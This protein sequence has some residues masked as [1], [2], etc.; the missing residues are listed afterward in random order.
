MAEAC[1]PVADGLVPGRC[2]GRLRVRAGRV[3]RGR[4]IRR[5]ERAPPATVFPGV[6]ILKPLHGA[7]PGLYDDLT[8]FCNQE[9]PGAVQVL[10]GVRESTDAAI[11][12][13]SRLIGDWP[14]RDFE[15][16][17]HSNA[18][19]PN[20]K[21][22][23]LVGMQDRI[24]HDV[25]ILADSDIAVA[26]DYVSRIV[27]ALS[28][29][30]VGLVTCLYRG[31]P[32]AGLWA[33]LA[34]ME[35]DY[36]FLP[37]VLV[38]TAGSALHVRVLVRRSRFG[39]GRSLRSADSRRSVDCLADDNAIGEAVRAAGMRVAIPSFRGGPCVLGA[40]RRRVAGV[41]SFAGRGPCGQ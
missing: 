18:S 1:V 5:G 22:A 12:V 13:V 40:E 34:S 14:G 2:D 15:L 23:N 35:I 31:A 7:E 27:A 17:V 26:R 33:R 24:R 28:R 39:A 37:D 10:F 3:R 30:D 29:P 36:R 11:A 4:T 25:V 20:P 41:M 38:G 8:S 16:V 9:Y 32:R 19:G 6:T 21:I